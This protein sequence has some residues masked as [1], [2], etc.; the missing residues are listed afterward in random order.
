MSN[1]TSS[2]IAKQLGGIGRLSAMIGAHT[3]I[4]HGN[5]LSFKFKGS[6]VATYC[7]VEMDASDT[8]TVTLAKIRK[9][10]LHKAQTFDGVYAGQLRETIERVTGLYLSLGT[11]GR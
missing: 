5:A 7:K 2:T 10:E 4:D 1:A 3:F 8:Y 9:W 11:C 6:R